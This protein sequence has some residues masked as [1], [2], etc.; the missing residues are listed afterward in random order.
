[1]YLGVFMFNSEIRLGPI[2]SEINSPEDVK[3]LD[4]PQLEKLA[5]ELRQYIIAV[6]SRNG[7]HLA[8]NL[9]TVELSIALMYL[10]E[11]PKDKIIWD[12]SHQAYSYKIL[13]ER[14][15]A[16]RN[17]R[18]KGGICG[19]Q[20]RFE[21]E[22]DFFGSGHASTSIS[23]A[24]GAVSARKL[25]KEDYRVVSIIG[26]G[27]LTGGLAFEGLNNAG[28]LGEEML[29]ILNDNEMS[30]SHNVGALTH[31]LTH[32]TAHPKYIKL[33]DEIWDLTGR[34]KKL[35]KHVRTF[36]RKFEDS[37]K[38]MIVPSILFEE[39]GFQYYG[40]VDGHNIPELIELLSHIKTAQFPKLLHIATKKGKGYHFA[41]ENAK[42]FHGLGKFDIHTGE[43]I[44]STGNKTYSDILGDTAIEF[45]SLR[46]DS[47]YITAA[48]APGTGLDRFS[49]LYP[50]RFFDVGIAEEHAVV[51]GASL[52][53]KGLKPVV[54]IYSTFLQRAYDQLIHDVALQRLPVLFMLDRAGVVGSDGPTH[55]GVFDLA[56]LRT[57]PGMIIAAPKDEEE[58]RQLHWTALNYKAGP[59][60][61]R[62]QRDEVEGIEHKPLED[63]EIGSWE[64]LSN[65][66][67]G[68]VLAV[69]SMVKPSLEIVN[70]LEKEGYGLSL[71]N[72]RF[73]KPL[74][75]KSI[76]DILNN[77]PPF[78]L[79]IEEGTLYGGFGSAILERVNGKVRVY[80]HGITDQFVEHG[81]R[82]E[83]LE[84]LNLDKKGIRK[85]IDR[86][87]NNKK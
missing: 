30:I 77:P 15:E 41:E 51:F 11:P 36:A 48:M 42:K 72:A 13:T 4:I 44:I 45:A 14:K 67:D 80:R 60:A 27:A 62:Y 2:L 47:V 10:Y 61:V 68:V 49:E 16:F 65:G 75:E 38:N 46:E 59:F 74:D 71:Y 5:D 20:N 31:Y 24:C 50:E 83:L 21:S 22:Y 86:I 9:G 37:V 12:V 76:T 79:T 34:L 69:G 82:K 56:Y 26:D 85:V 32:L 43:E 84:L 66:N 55:H 53:C 18:C 17:I 57:V 8:P 19:Y 54:A 7:G 70:E 29:V 35:S 40:P 81:S 58:F 25:L 39:F 87:L 78:I 52:A 63:I 64:K 73:I 3:K 6:V 33:K 23:A 1:M 28:A